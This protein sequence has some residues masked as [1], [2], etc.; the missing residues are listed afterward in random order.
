MSNDIYHYGVKGM[1]W[2][3]RKFYEGKGHRY[4]HIGVSKFNKRLS[5]H[6]AAQ[7][8]LQKAKASKDA[9]AKKSAKLDVKNTKKALNKQYAQLR[10]DKLAD[11]G[12]RLHNRGET[13]NGLVTKAIT[14]Q[15]GFNVG[16]RATLAL[17]DK[18]GRTNEA[19]Y[20]ANGATVVTALLGAKDTKDIQRLRAYTSRK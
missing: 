15:I 13:V 19:I 8:R 11:E 12:R 20:V 4:T 3:V 18:S 6:E 10:L 14:K 7:K 16:V 1:K 5:E 17:L 2:G 9:V